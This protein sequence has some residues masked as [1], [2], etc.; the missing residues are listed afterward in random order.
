MKLTIVI[1]VYN[2]QKTIKKIIDRVQAAN[3]GK[4]Q[5]EIIV[6]NDCSTDKTANEL[7][8]IKSGKNLQILSHTINQGKG[9]AIRTGMKRATGDYLIIQDA[10][11]EYDP[12]DISKLLQVVEKQPDVVVYGSRFNGQHEDTIFGHKLGNQ[13]LTVIT[14]MLFGLK[15]SDME[16]CYKL[17][18]RSVYSGIKIDSDRFNF[19]PEVTAKIAK[20]GLPII[21]V[22]V[23]YSKRG[24]SEGKNLKWWSDGPMAILTLLKYRFL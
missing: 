10:D 17:M 13:M 16:T 15:I 9:A 2:E 4:W 6:V 7:A 18:P 23:S 12:N 19:E 1:P 22:P 21:E 20:K 3:F 14:N 8:K 5:K 11:F 24:F